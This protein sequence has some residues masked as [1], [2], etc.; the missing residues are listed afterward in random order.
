M[1]RWTRIALAILLLFLFIQILIFAPKDLDSLLGDE[2]KP[3]VTKPAE[4]SAEQKMGGVHLVESRSGSRDWELFARGAEGYEGKNVWALEQM[5]VIFYSENGV[6]FTVTGDKGNI[7]VATKNMDISGNV[8]MNSSNGYHFRSESMIYDA[9]TRI[10]RAPTAIKMEGPKLK[11]E[12]DMQVEGNSMNTQL[13]DNK[14]TVTGAVKTRKRV[15][16]KKMLIVSQ[17]AQFSAANNSARFVGDVEIE[18]DSMKIVGP[19]A[20]FR[21]EKDTNLLDSVFVDGGVRVSDLDKWATSENVS[22]DFK[23]DQFVFRGAPR[24]VQNQDELIGEEIV[25]QNGGKKVRVKGAKSKIDESILKED[26]K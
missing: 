26:E 13:A 3:E 12:P 5:K 22:V 20:E 15:Q 18:V 16:E 1:F 10:I 4:N 19:E 17:M 23:N 7:E 24:V 25:F 2:K 11:N 21:Y 8:V 9:T 14:M 6:T